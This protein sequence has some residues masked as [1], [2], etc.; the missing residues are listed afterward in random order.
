LCGSCVAREASFSTVVEQ[1]MNG[2][3]EER[4]G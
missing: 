2:I 3:A 4:I 1:L